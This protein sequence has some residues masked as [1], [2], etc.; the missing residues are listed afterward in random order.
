[1]S[2]SDTTQS[3][4]QLPLLTPPFKSGA[5]KRKI[6]TE[7]DIQPWLDSEAYD[8]LET[9][10]ARMSYAVDGKSVEDPCK[11]SEVRHTAA[12]CNK[13]GWGC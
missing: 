2:T 1:M 5:P 12:S 8:Y 3:P 7:A 9:L 11:E 13:W 6:F 10:I 4:Q